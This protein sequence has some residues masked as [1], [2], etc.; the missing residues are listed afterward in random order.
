M[1]NYM[2]IAEM[3]VSSHLYAFENKVIKSALRYFELVQS[4]PT[5]V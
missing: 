3:E 1:L 4:G 2:H 5:K